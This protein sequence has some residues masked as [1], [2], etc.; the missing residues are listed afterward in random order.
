MVTLKKRVKK[1]NHG[2]LSVKFKRW[3]LG[4]VKPV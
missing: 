4:T 1:K 2:I 3:L